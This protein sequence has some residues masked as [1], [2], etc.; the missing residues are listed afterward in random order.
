MA[1]KLAFVLALFFLVLIAQPQSVTAVTYD[2][3]GGD[4]DHPTWLLSWTTYPWEEGVS[5]YAGAPTYDSSDPSWHIGTSALPLVPSSISSFAYNN[6]TLRYIALEFYY[7]DPP[8]YQMSFKIN[9]QLYF[10]NIN[11]WYLNII[12]ATDYTQITSSRFE[13]SGDN[14][15][16]HYYI[17]SHPDQA[18]TMSRI[19]YIQDNGAHY[20]KGYF[21]NFSIFI[22]GGEVVVNPVPLP[23]TLLLLGSGLAGLAL[24]RRR[25][26]R[27][28]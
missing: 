15:D 27:R 3:N 8:S 22:E 11:S 12:L 14:P 17:T 1:R 9:D 7:T 19:A 25:R 21:N 5:F 13:F 24:A 16:L 23:G 2:L 18:I 28:S 4:Q 6:N 26:R 20:L 10:S